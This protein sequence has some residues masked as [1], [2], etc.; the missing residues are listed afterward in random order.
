[1]S[2]ILSKSGINISIKAIENQEKA[3]ESKKIQTLNCTKYPIFKAGKLLY[4]EVPMSALGL[5]LKTWQDAL[6]DLKVK[7]IIDR[8]KYNQTP[9]KDLKKEKIDIYPIDRDKYKDYK[10]FQLDFVSIDFNKRD[11]ANFLTT[12]GGKTLCSL[13]R[14]ANMRCQKMLLITTISNFP[15]WEEACRSQLGLSPLTFTGTKKQRDKLDL[16]KS[17]IVLTNYDQIKEILDRTETDCFDG[18]V[19]DEAHTSCGN[20]TNKTYKYAETLKKKNPNRKSLIVC[21]ATPVEAELT[22]L[23]SI[24]NLTDPLVAG[25]LED[26]LGEF[27]EVTRWKEIRMKNGGKFRQP[28]DFKFKDMDKLRTLLSTIA[29]RHDLSDQM[30]FEQK[31]II[32]PLEMTPAQYKMYLSAVQEFQN[33]VQSG[34]L[35]ANAMVQAQKLFRMA[36]GHFPFFDIVG[37]EIISNKFEWLKKNLHKEGPKTILS[38][39]SVAASE[40]YYSEFKYKA[41]IHNGDRSANYKKLGRIAFN[42]AKDKEEEEFYYKNRSKYG[43]SFENPG[44]A[45]ILIIVAHGST[46]VGMNLPAAKRQIL[47]SIPLSARVLDQ[48]MGRNRRL[49]TKHNIEYNFLTSLGTIDRRFLELVLN[50]ISLMDT[51]LDGKGSAKSIKTRDILKLLREKA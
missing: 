36:E 31:P 19:F 49:D 27:Q 33:L 6:I 8:Y 26:F 44:D 5:V 28:I 50:K 4:Y 1:L 16:D 29:F 12:G 17:N 9:L 41:V 32:T 37:D 13:M 3:A 18:I 15:D 48:L 30:R 14:M 7:D 21:T 25:R 39:I 35:N 45:E 34:D 2:V 47:A 40:A 51:I 10:D 11:I 22:P 20:Y 46:V 43:L 24:L 23:W 42:G 38:T